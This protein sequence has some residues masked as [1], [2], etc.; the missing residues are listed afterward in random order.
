MIAN[1][2][3]FDLPDFETEEL[4]NESVEPTGLLSGRDILAAIKHQ[5]GASTE[6]RSIRDL[7]NELR[8]RHH[9]PFHF[10]EM[11]TYWVKGL[12]WYVSGDAIEES[13][14]RVYLDAV[15]LSFDSS[16][17]IESAKITTISRE[18][19]KVFEEC[20]THDW[21]GYNA[22]PI[23]KEAVN[24]ALAFIRD[25]A[26]GVLPPEVVPE[27]NGNLAFEWSDDMNHTF[28]VSFAGN[29]KLIYAGM[30]PNKAK[31][32]GTQELSETGSFLM[33]T[34]LNAYFTFRE[35]VPIT[36]NRS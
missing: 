26:S 10:S 33:R 9:S 1:N 28:V 19:W 14:R 21:D 31:L 7:S 16:A 11:V 17:W 8:Q 18:I 25:L 35:N 3:L 23:S 24:D 22:K 36:G 13:L 20:S 12:R 6:A 32:H 5:K 4:T 2:L 30:L 29:R 34:I 15:K 27:P